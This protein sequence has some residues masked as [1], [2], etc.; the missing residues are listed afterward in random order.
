[1]AKS[2]NVQVLPEQDGRRLVQL[3]FDDELDVTFSYAIG[4]PVALHGASIKSTGEL[5]A[6]TIRRASWALWTTVAEAAL[7]RHLAGP[8][9]YYVTQDSV[10]MKDIE[11]AMNIK[12]EHP[13]A[14]PGPAP[15][16]E[17]FY[18]DIARRY[19]ARLVAMD[20]RPTATMAEEDG[21]KP[22]TMRGYV[23]QARKRN[24]LGAGRSG[25]AG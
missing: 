13:R 25:K 5:T 7:R 12:G 20:R 10:E 16:P 21:V 24:L 19:E 4:P 6:T 18:V 17:Q 2:L 3:T 1:M 11:R 8:S 14:R 15:R 23:Y 9:S 22:T